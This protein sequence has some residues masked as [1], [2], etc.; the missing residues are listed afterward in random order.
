MTTVS[1]IRKEWGRVFFSRLTIKVVL[2]RDADRSVVTPGAS[3]VAIGLVVSFHDGL[4]Y[5]MSLDASHALALLTDANHVRTESADGFH[6]V[7]EI[8][9]DPLVYDRAVCDGA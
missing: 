9:E 5:C 4:I 8:I 3:I 7:I 1:R 2:A 6:L